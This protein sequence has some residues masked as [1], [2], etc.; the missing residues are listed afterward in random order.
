M[1]NLNNNYWKTNSCPAIMNDGRG[2]MTNFVNNKILVQKLKSELNSVSPNKFRAELQKK[3]LVFVDNT[4]ETNKKNFIC[5]KDP[6]GE[7]KLNDKIVLN[8]GPNQSFLDAFKP[9]V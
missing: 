5:N 6:R 1:S 7:I 4:L 9:L 2:V 8:N 3:G